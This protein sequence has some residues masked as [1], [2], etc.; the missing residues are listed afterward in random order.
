MKRFL[1]LTKMYARTSLRSRQSLGWI[2]LF[3]VMMML[4]WGYIGR[5]GTTQAGFG[6]AATVA[7]TGFLMGSMMI[8]AA[9]SQ[10]VMGNSQGMT[11]M[12]EEGILRRVRCTPLPTWIF[13]LSRMVVEVAI[14]LVGCLLVVLVAVGLFGVRLSAQT[15]PAALGVLLLA[16]ALFI[17]F[18]QLIAALARKPETARAAAQALNLPL[19]FIGG[20][21][22]QPEYFP[23]PL[24]LIAQWTPTAVVANLLRPALLL[25]NLG[26]RPALDLAVLVGY[27][28]VTLAL[29]A[30]F[31][32]WEAT[33]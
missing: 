29:A 19:M 18:G 9:L 3:P 14:T 20:L 21:F 33:A 10:G 5:N 2:I 24:A 23:K 22:L 31:F 30:R 27:L 15:L 6:S 4:F 7:Y 32:R 17:A 16:I 11:N 12:R 28:A 25:G 8:M 1:T 13:L 26:P